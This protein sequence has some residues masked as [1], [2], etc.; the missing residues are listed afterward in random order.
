[1]ATLSKCPGLDAPSNPSAAPC[2]ASEV[3]LPSADH[4]F[5]RWHEQAST[6]CGLC[7]LGVACFL[8]RV[9]GEIGGIVELSRVDEDRRRRHAPHDASRRAKQRDMPVVQGAHCRHQPD[10]MTSMPRKLFAQSPR[11]CA[12]FSSLDSL[13]LR[14]RPVN[15]A[16]VAARPVRGE[17]RL[18]V[19]GTAVRAREHAAAER[20]N[21]R[22]NRLPVAARDWPRQFEAVVDDTLHERKE[23]LGRRAREFKHLHGGGVQRHEIVRCDRGARH[24]TRPALFAERKRKSPVRERA[25]CHGVRRFFSPVMAAHAP[26]SCSGPRPGT[27]D[28]KWMETESLRVRGQRPER[29]RAARV[30]DPRSRCNRTCDVGDSGVGYTEENEIRASVN[31]LMAPVGQTRGDRTAYTSVADDPD[32]LEHMSRQYA[33]SP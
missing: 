1:M 10:R 19:H 24:D 8:P 14:V 7:D 22:L 11:P 31:E 33:L 2:T 25:S 3:A 20:R 30:G 28:L 5:D 32:R 18:P 16:V 4:L 26:S 21:M 6:P 29:C 17:S 12:G 9:G 13:D 27:I 15:A 23:S